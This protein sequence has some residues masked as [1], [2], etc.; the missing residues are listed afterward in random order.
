M[1]CNTLKNKP[2]KQSHMKTDIE[3]FRGKLGE[4]W[5][6]YICLLKSSLHSS[7]EIADIY[8]KKSQVN[9]FRQRS[10]Y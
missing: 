7:E 9:K 5:E 2:W 10:N 1:M 4:V 3:A 8:L 6:I